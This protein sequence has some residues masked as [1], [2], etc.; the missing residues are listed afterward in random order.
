MALLILRVV[1]EAPP[2]DDETV[3]RIREVVAGKAGRDA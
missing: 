3:A 1:D 2:L